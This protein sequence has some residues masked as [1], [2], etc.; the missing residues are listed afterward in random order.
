MGPTDLSK[1]LSAFLCLLVFLLGC[2][3]H[4]GGCAF[5]PRVKHE[6]SVDLQWIRPLETL[7]LDPPAVV[8]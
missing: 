7:K 4:V 2:E 1:R 5:S 6:R 8:R 3:I